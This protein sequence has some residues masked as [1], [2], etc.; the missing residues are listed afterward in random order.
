[1]LGII[2]GTKIRLSK[3]ALNNIEEA[4]G[5][6]GPILNRR[7]EEKNYNDLHPG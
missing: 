4:F 5:P 7:A 6:I 2:F 1:L 3:W